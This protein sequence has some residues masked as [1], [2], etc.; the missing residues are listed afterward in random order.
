MLRSA[1]ATRPR[2]TGSW[3]S[4][5]G[6]KSNSTTTRAASLE[7][8]DRIAPNNPVV[9]QSVYNHSYL[10]GALVASKIDAGTPDPPGGRIEKD[11]AGKPTG[12][13]RGAGGVAFVAARVPLQNQ[14][15]W[16]ANTRKLVA[17]L[18]SLGLTAWLDAGGRGMSARHYAPTSSS[19]TAASSTSACSGR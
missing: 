10:N 9:L 18:N 14:D 1:C 19:P 15:A 16:L 6:R 7:E 12:L 3:F 4:A 5:A 13:V 2:G 17:Y 8:L 11:A